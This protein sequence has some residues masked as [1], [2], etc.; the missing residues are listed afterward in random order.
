MFSRSKKANR[1]LSESFGQLKYDSY[2]FELIEKYFRN[3]EDNN[4][5]QVLS[6]RTCNDIDFQELFMFLDRTSSKIGQQFLFNKLR[7]IPIN[8]NKFE[9]EEELINKLTVEYD[10]RIDTQKLLE[11]L[12]G[13][14][15]YYI[16]SLFQEEH[17]K[18]P[19]WFT[20]VPV[21]A[22][23]SL[24][25]I[26]LLAFNPY[27]IF[28]FLGVLLINLGIHF[29][30]KK[31]LYQYYGSI[32]QLLLLN[33]IAHRLYKKELFRELSPSLIE[34][35]KIIDKVRNRMS[36]FKFD[37]RY[38]NNFELLFWT[39]LELLKAIFLL[40]PLLLFGVLKQLNTKR[41]EIDNVFS[42]VGLIDSLISVASLR[43]GLRQY[44][45]PDIINNSNKIIAK[46]V[47]HPLI[48]DCI[49]NSIE[50]D[51]KSILLTGSNMSG[52]TTFIRTVGINVIVGLTINTCFAE[53]FSMPRT[54]IY[55]AIRISDD[56]MN[57]K[58]YYFEEVSTIKDML[59]KSEEGIP[60]LFLLDEIFK[61]TNTIER[62]AAGKAVL[63]VL[64]GKNNIVFVSTHDIELA[65][66]LKDEYVLFHFSEAVDNK[67]IYF[68]YKLKEGKLRIRNAIRILQINGYPERIIN[69]AIKISS[70]LEEQTKL[71]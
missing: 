37:V 11:K 5:F 39:F 12:N 24:F 65:D 55:S 57:D 40:E 41:R 71:V 28:L 62:I 7:V 18:P 69:E 60:N 19:K 3:K 59:D 10:L 42:F 17:L 56:L 36:F 33:G 31:N 45:Y 30:N 67:A 29:W 43:N 26:I 35:I 50:V 8:S 61:G 9:Y 34:S 25:S 6:D 48:L 21:L 1:R 4:S 70:E 38:S 46:N 2:N 15:A 44:C 54:R 66:L 58:S 22:F 68:D 51:K 47:Y 52:K 63:S 49:N 14:E 20:I 53:H 32:P 23:T 27:A 64:S 16:T 13:E